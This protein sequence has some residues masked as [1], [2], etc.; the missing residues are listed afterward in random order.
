AARGAAETLVRSD[1]FDPSSV[2]T[3]PTDL[4]RRRHRVRLGLLVGTAAVVT[5]TVLG[6]VGSGA[7]P[8]TGPAPVPHGSGALDPERVVARARTAWD[9]T[10][11]VDFTAW[12]ARGALT[13]DTDLLAKALNA[14]AR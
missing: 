14:W 10:S 1:E 11:R 12:P 3:R 4:L 6:L 5:G 13:K 2:R 7:T 8:L 9:D